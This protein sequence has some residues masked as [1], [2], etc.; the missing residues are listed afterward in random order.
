ML[1]CAVDRDITLKL[2]QPHHA[3][4]FF[5]VTEQN[6]QHLRSWLPWVDQSHSPDDTRT[7]IKASLGLLAETR[8][9]AC[10]IWLHK[11]PVGCIDLHIN[12]MNYSAE[13]GYW[14]AAAAQGKGIMTKSC[15]QVIAYGFD[16]LKLNRLL[17][18]AAVENH[19]SRSIPERLGFTQE[20]IARQAIWVNDRYLDLVSYSL[21]A[22]EWKLTTE[23]KNQ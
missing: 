12:P 18:R 9:V 15:R 23:Q 11:E 17:I 4:A 5:A 14:L 2:L 10:G 13:I 22:D 8:G 6:R 1:S 19:R 16:E 7:F 3:E 20:G 21:L